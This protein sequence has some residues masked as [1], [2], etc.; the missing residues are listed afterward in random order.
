MRKSDIL[1]NSIDSF[2]CTP[3]NGQTLVQILSKEFWQALAAWPV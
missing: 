1:L 3:E 2:Y